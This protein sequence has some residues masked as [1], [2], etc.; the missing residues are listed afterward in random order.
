MLCTSDYKNIYFGDNK[1]CCH[2]TLVGKQGCGNLTCQS[3]FRTRRPI[4]TESDASQCN[5]AISAAPE[6]ATDDAVPS[7]RLHYST[8]PNSCHY[9]NCSLPS[10][11]MINNVRV[12]TLVFRRRCNPLT[13]SVSSPTRY[14]NESWARERLHSAV[15]TVIVIGR[16]LAS[17]IG[18]HVPPLAE[19]LIKI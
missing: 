13:S 6:S 18:N 7:C 10:A 16:R 4:R 3:T 19:L 14:R 17:F 9:F 1:Y 12:M 2:K 5:R 11:A 15:S 8:L